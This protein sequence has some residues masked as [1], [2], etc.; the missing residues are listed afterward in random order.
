MPLTLFPFG[1]LL[2]MDSA[3]ILFS[4]GPNGVSIAG[5]EDSKIALTCVRE[6]DTERSTVSWQELRQRVGRFSQALRAHGVKKGDRVAGVVS[7]SADALI[8]MLATSAIG[9]IYSTS[10]TDMGTKGILD[11]M[12]QI[13]P[14]YI[15]MDDAA[16]YNR[17]KT[18]LRPKIAEIVAGMSAVAAF[19]GIVSLP[20]FREPV[21]T[22]GIQRWYLLP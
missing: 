8:L 20:R 15:F 4:K 5:K 10:A 22:S 11:R 1:I 9:A 21:D 13:E 19:R 7:N 14:V 6:G 3:Q 18:D 2:L 17:K 12:L 16:V